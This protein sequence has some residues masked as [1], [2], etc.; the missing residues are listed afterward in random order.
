MFITENEVQNALDNVSKN[1]VSSSF[2]HDQDCIL[3]NTLYLKRG[4]TIQSGIIDQTI[5]AC[6]LTYREPLTKIIEELAENKARNSSD[7]IHEV[8]TVADIPILSGNSMSKKLTS[9]SSD[10]ITNINDNVSK[11]HCNII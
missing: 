7:I 3:F 5:T 2:V 6:P 9:V 11:C 4:C 10:M 1:I 8:S